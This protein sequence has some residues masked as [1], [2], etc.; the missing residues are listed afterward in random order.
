[1]RYFIFLAVK[2]IQNAFTKVIKLNFKRDITPQ[3]LN[4]SLIR[5]DL[6]DKFILEI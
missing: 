5:A 1:M 6:F 3:K 2:K 4:M